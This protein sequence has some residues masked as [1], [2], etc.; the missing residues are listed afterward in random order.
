[1]MM[2]YIIDNLTLINGNK[3]IVSENKK[4]V[5]FW[6]VNISGYQGKRVTRK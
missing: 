3:K 2:I 5:N 6:D 1:M 4:Y